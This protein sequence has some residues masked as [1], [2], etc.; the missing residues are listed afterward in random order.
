MKKHIR[1]GA[2][3]GRHEIPFIENYIFNEIKN[4]HDYDYVRRGVAE[5]LKDADRVDLYVTGLTS[6][7]AEA[8]AFCAKRGIVLFLFHY[9][10]DTDIYRAQ[11]MVS[12]REAWEIRTM[13]EETYGL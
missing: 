2:V 6:V 5:K 8:V 1:I 9:D 11:V 13:R 12:A 10:R 4:V 3:A 7:V